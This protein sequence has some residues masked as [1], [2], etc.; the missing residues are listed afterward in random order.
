MPL[1]TEADVNAACAAARKAFDAGHWSRV[2]P[3]ERKAVL[4]RLAELI[5]ESALD[6]AELPVRLMRERNLLEE[7]EAIA[8]R[9]AE[10]PLLQ[11][12]ARS[13]ARQLTRLGA[14]APAPE[15]HPRLETADVVDAK[16]AQAISQVQKS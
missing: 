14:G 2:A 4:L 6:D 1:A 16:A 10:T 12:Y 9:A 7:G 11:F 8:V 5:R 3:R 13:I 15:A